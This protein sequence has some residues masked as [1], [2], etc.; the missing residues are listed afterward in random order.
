MI[1]LLLLQAATPAAAP[2]VPERFSILIPACKPDGEDRDDIVVC[3]RGPDGQRLPFPEE[4]GPPDRPVPGN[5]DMTGV[6][7]LAM[8]ATPCAATQGGCQVGFN[9]LGPP[10]AAVR[11]LTKLI[12]PK[13]DCCEPGEATDPMLLARDGLRAIKA[14]TRKKPD[15][16]NRI[17]IPLED[18][19]IPPLL[20]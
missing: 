13:N 17:A 4:R 9:I 5:P 1:A 6:G 10:V 14:M 12:N 15:T 8:E 19:P 16:S 3:A 7:A 11:L 2:P 18:D 20:P